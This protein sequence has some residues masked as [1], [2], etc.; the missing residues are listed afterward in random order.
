M[1]KIRQERNDTVRSLVRALDQHG[2]GEGSHAARVAVYAV[3]AAHELGLRDQEL[4][5]LRWAAELHDV[6]KVSIDPAILQKMG[7]LDDG[8]L[9][10]MRQH[11]TLAYRVLEEIAWLKNSLPAI[12]HHHERY[13]GTGY[14]EGL[15]GPDIP[16]GARIIA[17]AETY[18]VMVAG[19]SWKSAFGESEA[20][21]ELERCS[22]A[23][24]DP[25]VVTAFKKVQPLIQPLSL[26]E[27]G[28]S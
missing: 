12:V 19:T 11:A 16:L 28:R 21:E 15:V 26:L 1:D 18:D 8:E 24:F 14:P 9:E 23:Q 3:A 22:G 13:D 10:Q 2:P 6:G 20:L 25:N 17:V 7:S 5:E 27:V 4:L